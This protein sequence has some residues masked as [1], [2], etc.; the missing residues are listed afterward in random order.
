MAQR[1]TFSNAVKEIDK[2]EFIHD[3]DT[4]NDTNSNVVTY[5]VKLATNRSLELV[6][7]DAILVMV[8]NSS[9]MMH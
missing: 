5:S 8:I 1:T 2:L 3:L 4:N 7:K 9:A 6:F